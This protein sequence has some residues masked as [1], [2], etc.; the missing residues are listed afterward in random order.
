MHDP[1]SHFYY[2]R[3]FLLAKLPM[4]YWLLFD[5]QPYKPNSRNFQPILHQVAYFCQ[6]RTL[7]ITSQP[8]SLAF[9]SPLQF[10]KIL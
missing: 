5:L 4:Y 2:H 10:I 9:F 3:T 6:S 1:S 8:G 7:Q